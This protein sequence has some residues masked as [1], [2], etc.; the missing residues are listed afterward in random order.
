MIF[1]A[2]CLMFSVFDPL[3]LFFK[4]QFFIGHTVFMHI[5]FFLDLSLV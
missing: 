2:I 3:V 1:I 4:L 5:V